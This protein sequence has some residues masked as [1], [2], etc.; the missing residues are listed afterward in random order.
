LIEKNPRRSHIPRPVAWIAALPHDSPVSC[1]SVARR[2]GGRLGFAS[3]GVAG[4]LF[5]AEQVQHERK[6]A[7]TAYVPHWRP[8]ASGPL[9]MERRHKQAA[10][11]N[12]EK[13]ADADATDDHA[14]DGA[15]QSNECPG[16]YDT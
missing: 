12:R 11:R 10:P 3:W 15:R 9:V 1:S 7:T 2:L 14:N 13:R 4:F 6:V 5:S 8:L 16:N